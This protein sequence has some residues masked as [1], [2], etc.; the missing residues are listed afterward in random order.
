VNRRLPRLPFETPVAGLTLVLWLGFGLAIN[1]YFGILTFSNIF[2]RSATDGLLV[3]GLTICLLGGQVDLSI[4]STLALSG[5]VWALIDNQGS[6]WLGVVAGIG[7]GAGIGLV[8]AVLVC[9]VGV[10]AFVATLG[11]LLLAKGLAF[12]ASSGQP[13]TATDIDAALWMNRNLFGFI[14]P[15]VINFHAALL[16][17]HLFITTTRWGRDIVAIGGNA[18]A[19]AAS[20]IPR[21][22][23]LTLAFCISGTLSGVAGV[24]LA[25]SLLAG[26]PT[27]GDTDLLNAA[28]AAFVAGVA[29]SGGRGSVLG[30]G[31]A[32]I[33]LSSLAAG[34]ELS[35]IASGYQTAITGVILVI[36][37]LAPSASR[38]LR[39]W[40]E[41][42]ARQAL[43][44]YR[45]ARGG[46][47]AP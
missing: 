39:L 43:G 25:I 12:F 42:S 47:G 20:G 11:T 36:A 4:G 9:V 24:V 15:R 35:F 17:A 21:I 44:R 19:A 27:I 38:W 5:V 10:D 46:Q 29:L 45:P 32:V 23:R 1:N 14:S 34:L 41:T 6:L 26:S 30:S 13:V 37:V 28:T 40:S 18:R 33:A 31:I 22:R 16:I 8:N 3:A 7:A 2:G